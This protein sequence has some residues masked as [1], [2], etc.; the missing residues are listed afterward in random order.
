[1]RHP[2]FFALPLMAC[3]NPVLAQSRFPDFRAKCAELAQAYNGADSRVE[4]MNFKN[5]QG[6]QQDLELQLKMQEDACSYSPD[7]AHLKVQKVGGSPI[8]VIL[9]VAVNHQAG[10]SERLYISSLMTTCETV[11]TPHLVARLK[12]D[13][14][15]IN[16]TL[17]IQISEHVKNDFCPVFVEKVKT[18]VLNLLNAL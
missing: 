10:G 8:E 13:G 9:D 14:V 18:S 11:S 5:F 16:E 3:A 15:V 6:R 4:K 2:F 1:M 7:K 12:D 17:K